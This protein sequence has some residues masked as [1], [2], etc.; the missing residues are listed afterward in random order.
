MEQLFQIEIWIALVGAA[1]IS[2]WLI[3]DWNGSNRIQR[4]IGSDQ[5][6]DNHDWEP[7]PKA[8]KRNAP[9]TQHDAVS[10]AFE[11]I[12]EPI[13]TSFERVADPALVQ[14][15]GLSFDPGSSPIDLMHPSKTQAVVK[16]TVD[17]MPSLADLHAQAEAI[18]RTDR[19]W[20]HLET[21][22]DYDQVDTKS[23]EILTHYKSSIK[24]LHQ[25]PP[26][27]K[28]DQPEAGLPR[29]ADAAPVSP[30][31]EDTASTDSALKKRGGAIRRQ[32][33]ES[34]AD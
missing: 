4:L 16:R 28:V 27:R 30:F 23:A 24:A 17:R 25:L 31:F 21:G 7:L 1:C 5:R 14:A 13:S 26:Q 34:L 6:I 10:K 18:R 33:D 12:T 22:I 8:L 15:A 3:G 19:V 2:G 9:V 11:T 20:D 29:F 32:R